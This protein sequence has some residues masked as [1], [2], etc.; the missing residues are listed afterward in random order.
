ML[1]WG[2]IIL[3]ALKL[4][5]WLIQKGQEMKWIAEGEQRQIAKGLIEVARKH[6]VAKGIL[7]EIAAVPDAQLDDILRGLEPGGGSG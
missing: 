2:Q 1:T 7:D 5:S 3:Y 4:I 6:E